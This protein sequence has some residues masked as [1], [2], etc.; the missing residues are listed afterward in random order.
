[1][2]NKTILNFRYSSILLFVTRKTSIAVLF[3]FML[4]SSNSIYSQNT[5]DFE[6]Y[7]KAQKAEFNKYKKT[8]EKEFK[9]FLQQHRDWKKT[10]LGIDVNLSR[11][12]GGVPAYI[13]TISTLKHEI[14]A[15]VHNSAEVKAL[16]APTAKLKEAAKVNI[17]DTKN[18][19]TKSSA[20]SLPT[21]KKENKKSLS[22]L[23]AEIQ[24]AS[25][26]KK[27]VIAAS[28]P[29][30]TSK[31]AAV[32]AT[33]SRT[34]AKST[35][36]KAYKTTATS[37]LPIAKP[38]IDR[39]YKLRVDRVKNIIPSMNPIKNKYRLSS[40]FGWRMHPI[41]HRRIH[42]DG[43]D[44]ACPRGTP[45]RIPAD[46]KVIKAGYNGGYGKYIL[47]QHAKG[48]KTAY[49]HLSY[50]NV[51]KGQ[52]IKK[53]SIIGKVGST[54]GS[55]GPHLHYEVIRNNRNVNPMKYFGSKS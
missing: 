5:S 3:I 32:T 18:E 10:I 21:P 24:K 12:D 47:V 28:K 45:V 44:M 8:Q 39:S 23:V 4:F 25:P 55:T 19:D 37:K 13:D 33:A 53:N 6:K 29:K 35:P 50:I 36:V 7:K 34:T 26:K 14:D 11:T 48:Y 27:T 43:V 1:M 22:E 38:G 15:L 16:E 52:K 31:P 2:K 9:K 20:P 42:H 46:G 49:A 17:P 41:H 54:G 51:R 30:A 40:K